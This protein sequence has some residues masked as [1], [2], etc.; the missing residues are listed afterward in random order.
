MTLVLMIATAVAGSWFGAGRRR[1]MP[2][3]AIQVGM[4][5][6]L[7]VAAGLPLRQGCTSRCRRADVGTLDLTGTRLALGLAGSFFLGAIMP[8][9]IGY[10]APCMI[11]VSAARHEPASRRFPIM[12]GACAFLMPVASMKFIRNRRYSLKTTVGMA[13]GGVFGSALALH[14]REGAWTFEQRQVAGDVRRH[15]HRDV[16]AAGPPPREKAAATAERGAPRLPGR[17]SAPASGAAG[18]R[19]R[20]ADHLDGLRREIVAGEIAVST[21]ATSATS[22]P[23]TGVPAR[24]VQRKST[25]T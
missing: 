10:Y 19:P 16:A 22:L 15:L 23:A 12:M 1:R 21:S 8:L 6:A 3:R 11:L 24:T 5:V 4:G 13:I 18:E 7:L 9:G 14:R 17:G 20:A 2:R 25:S